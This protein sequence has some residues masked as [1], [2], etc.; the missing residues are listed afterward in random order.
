MGATVV[1]S[2]EESTYNGKS[3]YDMNTTL[4]WNYNIDGHFFVVLTRK[5]DINMWNVSSLTDWRF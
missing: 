5:L 4:T 2:A 3:V 1:L